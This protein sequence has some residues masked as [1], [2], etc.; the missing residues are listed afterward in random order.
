[1]KTKEIIKKQATKRILNE[2]ERFNI[3][4]DDLH[5]ERKEIAIPWCVGDIDSAIEYG[6][7]EFSPELT[8]EEKL[9]ALMRVKSYHD[10]NVGISWDV[11]VAHLEDMFHDR[12]VR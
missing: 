6:D 9:N 2:M 12:L 11:I 5:A 1:M 10:A 7:I 8:E 4:M 3:S